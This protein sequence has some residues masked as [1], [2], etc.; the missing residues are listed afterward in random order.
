MAKSAIVSAALSRVALTGA[1]ALA[2]LCSPMIIGAA[3]AKVGVTSATDGDPLGKPPT[4]AE[5]VLR[6]GIDVQA[7]EAITTRASDRAHLVFLDGTSV[8]IGPDANIVIDKF[9]YDP[10]RKT[11]DLAISVTKGVFRLVGGKISKTNTIVVNT[12]SSSVGIRG[13]ITLFTVEPRKTSSIF[14]F[15]DSMTIG[16]NGRIEKVTRPGFE[17]TTNLG[18]SPG[19][20]TPSTRGQLNALLGQFEGSKKGGSQGGGGNADQSA[21][22]SGFSDTNSGRGTNVDGSKS[23]RFGSGP[24]PGNRNPSDVV[25]NAITQSFET[26]PSQQ[27]LPVDAISKATILNSTITYAG[28]MSGAVVNNGRS[29]GATGTYQNVWNVGNRNGVAGATFDGATYG[30]GSQPNTFAS[31]NSAAFK[32]ITPLPSTSGQPGRSLN[33]VGTFTGTQAN[34][35]QSQVGGF[36]VTGPRYQAQGVFS[37]QQQQPVGSK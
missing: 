4:E 6:V 21:E 29:Y 17:V 9:V 1:T 33:L 13:G 36:T 31:G 22:K 37:A 12:P 8:T 23:D 18:G 14:I 3:A 19:R 32:S 5:R 7:N 15:G 28:Q 24:G 34:P 20:A 25:T 16:A 27:P 35:T 30:G 2:L 10:Q 11:G 26:A